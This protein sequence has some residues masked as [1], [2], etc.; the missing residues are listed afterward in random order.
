[1]FYCKK[2]QQD[3]L[4]GC[5]DKLYCLFFEV[6]NFLDEGDVFV[7]LYDIGQYGKQK[8]FKER[9][10]WCWRILR[11]GFPWCDQ[12]IFTIPRAKTFAK[13]ILE[14]VDRCE[15]I[16]RIAKEEQKKKKN[17]KISS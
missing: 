8:G 10:R 7:A 5:F 6:N 9:L 16:I 17:W 1:M 14:E 13:S 2:F 3:Q 15:N 12:V 4:K 11:T